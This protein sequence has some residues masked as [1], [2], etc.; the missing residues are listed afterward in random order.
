M[1]TT[2]KVTHKSKDPQKSQICFQKPNN[3]LRYRYIFEETNKRVL[4]SYAINILF[5]VSQFMLH[6]VFTDERDTL[7]ASDSENTI[8]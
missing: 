6:N 5:L 8:L 7:Y 2:E 4:K 3:V 1:Q